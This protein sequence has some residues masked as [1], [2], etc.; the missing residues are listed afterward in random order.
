MAE[1]TVLFELDRKGRATVTLNRPEAHNAFDDSTIRRLGD[2]FEGIRG[3]SDVRVVV[4]A[5]RGKSF[6][7]GGDLNWMRRMAAMTEEENL[8][9]ALVLARLMRG[10]DEL[11]VP[12]IARVHGAAMGGGV[13]LA[14]CCDVVVAAEG[15]V[16]SLSEV[17][18][19]LIP[20]VVSPYVI[21]AIGA[22]QA[23]RYFMTAERF[24]AAE[25]LRIGL[26]HVV[27]PSERLDST[28][29]SVVESLLAGG[30]EAIRATKDL[31]L[32]VDG[33]VSEELMRETA[34][35]IARARAS[36]EGREGVAA[37]LEKRAPKWRG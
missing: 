35:R 29:D 2:T 28:V 14:S 37:F 33:R 10:L 36:P 32:E 7:A 31:A 17:R 25:A 20:A 24:D 30:P 6:S 18:I 8:A 34:A 22:R 5:G 19:G 13:G 4:L 12:T 21:A 11:P 15:A 3:Q 26:A 1:D 23:R 16:F 9:D 27:V